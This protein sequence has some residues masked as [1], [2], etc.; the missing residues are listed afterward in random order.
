L[1]IDINTLVGLI[2]AV[3]AKTARLHVVLHR[4]TSGAVSARELFKGSKDSAGL[5]GCN[6]K[7]IFGWGLQIFCE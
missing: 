5:V 1:Y 2:Q 7:K 3:R 6:E 4:N